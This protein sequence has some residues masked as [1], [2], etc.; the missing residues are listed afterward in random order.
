MGGGVIRKQITRRMQCRSPGRC[1]ACPE[2]LCQVGLLWV[3]M[4]KLYSMPSEPRQVPESDVCPEL[5]VGL[6]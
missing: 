1:S 4:V 5:D 6:D 2:G 3:G